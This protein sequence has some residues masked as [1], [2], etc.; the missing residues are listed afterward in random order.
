MDLPAILLDSLWGGLVAGSISMLFTVPHRYVP[1]TV[2]CGFAG[3][4][5]RDV[6]VAFGLTQNWSTVIA[7]AAIVL[8]AVALIRGHT[9]SPVMLA[10]SV[11]P[12]GATM[13]IF[14]AIVEL[15]KIS[16][17]SGEALNTSSVAFI[18]NIGKVFTTSLAIALGL[19]IG[20]VV[21]GLFR[22]E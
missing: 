9:V 7:A 4:C 6:L 22:R 3:R 19:G 1:G 20:M 21:V 14:G 10:A 15:L 5:A 18:A 12:L 16:T 13:A 11:I 2:L 8:I 17:L